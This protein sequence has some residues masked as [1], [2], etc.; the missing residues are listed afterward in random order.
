M[1]DDTRPQPRTTDPTEPQKLFTAEAIDYWK[2]V[3]PD[4]FIDAMRHEMM[5]FFMPIVGYIELI[6]E[7]SDLDTVLMK[8]GN[9]E[10]TL[11]DLCEVVMRQQPKVYHLR[12]LLF[13][14]SQELRDKPETKP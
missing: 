13:R 1:E 12:D 9:E 7:Q 4:K 14:Y 11:R 8:I 10:F 3:D 5:N 6:N 2:E